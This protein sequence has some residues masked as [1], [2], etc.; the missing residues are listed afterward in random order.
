MNTNKI[1]W[2]L[3]LS[4]GVFAL[5]GVFYY[6]QLKKEAE[7]HAA[8]G[9]AY[10]G[11]LPLVTPQAD[12][13]VGVSSSRSRS[14]KANRSES[15]SSQVARVAPNSTVNTQA[16]ST[17][18]FGTDKT[19]KPIK[20]KP[21][22]EDPN[23]IGGGSAV[24]GFLFSQS[25]SKSNVQNGTNAAPALNVAVQP[26]LAFRIPRSGGATWV[27]GD[28]GGDPDSWLE[29]DGSDLLVDPGEDPDYWL[30]EVVPAGYSIW[31]L[32]LASILYGAFRLRRRN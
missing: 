10:Y 4:I 26:T 32:A 30:P 29:E 31:L 12:L 20:R 3:L 5:G 9:E 22:K 19:V 23:A 7:L 17:P 14:H 18:S 28:P 24:P 25:T 2:I 27:G 6:V 15:L 8:R 21:K 16:L 11:D 1:I 13:S